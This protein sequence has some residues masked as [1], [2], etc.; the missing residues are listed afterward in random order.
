MNTLFIILGVALIGGIITRWRGMG[1][2]GEYT[3][4]GKTVPKFAKAFDSITGDKGTSVMWGLLAV[5]IGISFQLPL[6]HLAVMF[7]IHM[8]GYF[9]WGV[10][11]WGLYFSSTNGIW[12]ANEVE[13]PFID[14]ICYKF[15]PFVSETDY[16]TNHK[17]GTLGM[18]LRGFFYTIPY[19]AV[20]AGWNYY[21]GGSLL[22]SALVLALSLGALGQGIA[23]GVQW[24]TPRGGTADGEVITGRLLAVMAWLSFAIIYWS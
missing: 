11:G 16:E 1:F 13:R 9:L 23:Y 17:R 22:S 24:Y 2:A 6:L 8:L 20:L 14:W 10:R 4:V 19:F 7:V 5:A 15:F 3:Q 21:L 12:K 18:A